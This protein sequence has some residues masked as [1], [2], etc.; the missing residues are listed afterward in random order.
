MVFAVELR[1]ARRTTLTS[2]DLRPRA[3]GPIKTSAAVTKDDRCDEVADRFMAT[4]FLLYRAE[5]LLW[6]TLQNCFEGKGNERP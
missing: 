5:V 3:L 1:R 4:H 6:I 2:A